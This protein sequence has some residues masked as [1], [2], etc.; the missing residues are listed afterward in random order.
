MNHRHQ[1]ARLLHWLLPLL[2]SIVLAM[3][4][5][6]AFSAPS[7][8]APPSVELQY[9]VRVKITAMS[10]GGSS[11]IKWEKNGDQYN[12][13]T[14]A[15]GNA[16]GKV[17]DSSSRGHIGT[18]ELRP[19]LYREKSIGKNETTTTFNYPEK[20]LSFAPSGKSIPMESGIQDR[21]SMIWQL[22]SMMRAAPQKFTPGSKMKLKIA[23][24]NRLDVWSLTVRED[25]TLL[26]L[27]GE[28]NAIHLEIRDSK[29]KLIEA[30]MAPQKEYYP[31]KLI[32]DDH[33]NFRLEQ[34]IKTITKK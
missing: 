33:R 5:P 22:V 31:I 17:L 12:I 20:A 19:D 16:L 11:S 24:R 34:A 23:G 15:R 13:L 2:C 26:T 3:I 7:I 10:I 1:Q 21:A 6:S 8:S 29:N 9:V 32:F 4:H 18:A 27:L 25:V 14:S 30:W 28:L